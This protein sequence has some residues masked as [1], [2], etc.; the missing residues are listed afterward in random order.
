[1]EQALTY[2]RLRSKPYWCLERDGK[3]IHEF[4]GTDL[5]Q[6][7]NELTE[8]LQLL[9]TGRYTLK[10]RE[11]KN[12]QAGQ[13]QYEFT[14]GAKPRPTTAQPAQNMGI[15]AA[16]L[17]TYKKELREQIEKELR[18]EMRLQALEDSIIEIRNQLKKLTD[19]DDE[20]DESAIDR[21]TDVVSKM[22][23]LLSG[24]KGLKA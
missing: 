2:F 19:D 9:N 14:I 21:M 3:K 16:D 20:N 4:D 22:P 5:A 13:G 11:S 6:S 18:Q 24:L 10:V 23:G 1:M 7:E 8:Y 12:G 15:S 17:D